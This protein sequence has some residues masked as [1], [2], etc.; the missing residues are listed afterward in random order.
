M[1][2]EEEKSQVQALLD[3]MSSTQAEMLRHH[4]QLG[5]EWENLRFALAHR[6]DRDFYPYEMKI[7]WP[8]TWDG[9][10][11][12]VLRVAKEEGAQ[13]GFHSGSSLVDVLVTLAGRVSSGHFKTRPDDYEPEWYGEVWERI[14][15]VRKQIGG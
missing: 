14:T 13:V 3:E 15:E 8:K 2:T 7:R 10:F 9:D 4:Q 11:F 1:S 5:K 12:L 6:K